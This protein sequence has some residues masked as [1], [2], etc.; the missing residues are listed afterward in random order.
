MESEFYEHKYAKLGLSS[1][2]KQC[3]LKY[4]HDNRD[5]I[6][7]RKRNDGR[8]TLRNEQTRKWRRTEHGKIVA[9][10]IVLKKRYGISLIEYNKLLKEQDYK[11][12]VCLNSETSFDKRTNKL[13]DLSVDHNHKTGEVRGL[14]CRNCNTALGSL[15]DNENLISALLNYIR[16][17]KI[18]MAIAL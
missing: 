14:L 7:E 15:M 12:A 17:Y 18:A 13:R 6:N 1:Q 2:C 9:K 16:S 11:C 5:K 3:I 4:Q 8:N 10:S